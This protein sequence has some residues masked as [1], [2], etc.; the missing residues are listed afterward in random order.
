MFYVGEYGFQEDHQSDNRAV[1]EEYAISPSGQDRF[2]AISI[3]NSADEVICIALDSV[4]YD[5]RE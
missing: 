2:K 1:A 4:L 3:W 5:Q